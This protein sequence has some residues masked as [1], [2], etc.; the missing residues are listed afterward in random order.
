MT[1]LSLPMVAALLALAF[2]S[3]CAQTTAP[4]TPMVPGTGAP[5]QQFSPMDDHEALLRQN[6]IASQEDA[7]QAGGRNIWLQDTRR[8]N[9]PDLAQTQG[10]IK[11]NLHTQTVN[12]H[13]QKLP[14]QAS[15]KLSRST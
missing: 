10:Q 3:E 9:S 12:T 5:V 13:I 8:F 11:R 1:A 15:V 6:L 2:A 7:I 4:H 14:K